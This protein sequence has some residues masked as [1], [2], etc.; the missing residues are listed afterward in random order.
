MEILEEV[1][2]QAIKQETIKAD[3]AMRPDDFAKI[4]GMPALFDEK[5]KPKT[6]K[7]RTPRK[8]KTPKMK[9]EEGITQ[10]EQAPKKTRSRNPTPRKQATP[11]K[12]ENPEDPF[13]SLS[14]KRGMKA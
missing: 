7:K 13:T 4:E 9:E 5:D 14:Q 6:T 10:S 8:P 2:A 1:R 3:M 11:K 12:V